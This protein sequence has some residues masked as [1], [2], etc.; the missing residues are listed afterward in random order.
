MLHCWHQ[1]SRGEIGEGAQIDYACCY[2]GCGRIHKTTMIPDPK[3]GQAIAVSIP[4]FRL[5][6]GPEAGEHCPKRFGAQFGP[7][8]MA[9]G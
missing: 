9:S 5:I 2:C 8:P 3:H 7:R 6:A 1:V 4:S